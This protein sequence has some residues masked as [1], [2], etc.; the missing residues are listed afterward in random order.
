MIN[1]TVSGSLTESLRDALTLSQ[2]ADFFS[3]VPHISCVQR[4]ATRG[5]RGV[6]LQTWL[7]GGRRVTT[8]AA[9]EQFLME[10]NR[11][12]DAALNPDDSA[13]RSNDAGRALE[14]IGA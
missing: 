1:S 12:A 4:W 9:I 2:A 13:R 3:P 14:A 8:P 6:K 7:S 5:T 11:A 10:L